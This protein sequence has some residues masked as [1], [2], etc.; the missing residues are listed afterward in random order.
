MGFGKIGTAALCQKKKTEAGR[1]FDGT[2]LLGLYQILVP[3]GGMKKFRGAK[4]LPCPTFLCRFIESQDVF[5]KLSH[6]R[7]G[8]ERDRSSWAS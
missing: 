7:R 3:R 1:R 6:N 8:V 2:A 4:R 5:L